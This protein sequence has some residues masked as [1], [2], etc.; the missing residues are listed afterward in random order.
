MSEIVFKRKYRWVLSGE[1][2]SGKVEP[3]FVKV[4]ARPTV[5][6]EEVEVNFQDGKCFVPGKAQWDVIVVNIIE[7]EQEKLKAIYD[8]AESKEA[9]TIFLHLLDWCGTE[10]EKWELLDAKIANMKFFEW[11]HSS[12]SMVDVEL[13]ISYENVKYSN[14][15]VSSTGL[16]CL[17]KPKTKCPNCSHEF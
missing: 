7:A 11:D 9:G 6:I 17:G 10:L 12:T 4:D 2:P 16:G 3:M 14:N 8:N 13:N 5:K 15:C 1:F